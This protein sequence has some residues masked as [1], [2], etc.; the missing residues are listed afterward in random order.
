MNNVDGLSI[1]IQ[2]TYSCDFEVSEDA[3][4]F[5]EIYCLHNFGFDLIDLKILQ[6][7]Q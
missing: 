5:T 7:K 1:L 4:H 2:S 6:T 3:G